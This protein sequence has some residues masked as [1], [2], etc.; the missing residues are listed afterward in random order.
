MTTLRWPLLARSSAADQPDRPGADDDDRMVR[1][2]RRSWSAERRWANVSCRT[3][4]MP[5]VR[6]VNRAPADR[7]QC[8]CGDLGVQ[9]LIGWPRRRRGARTSRA[10]QDAEEGQGGKA[11]SDAT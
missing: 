4:V 8:S 5:A 6:P 2:L 9:A 11:A 1:R 3:S 7:Y 10:R